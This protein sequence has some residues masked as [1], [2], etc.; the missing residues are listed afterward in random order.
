MDGHAAR[1]GVSLLK[2]YRCIPS[3]NFSSTF[4]GTRRFWHAIVQW[5]LRHCASPALFTLLVPCHY[6]LNFAT[7]N[8]PFED[9]WGHSID[10]EH[11]DI[12]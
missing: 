5:A 11:L 2:L 3:T 4:V 10:C 9:A 6:T 7:L 12:L 1:F 8:L